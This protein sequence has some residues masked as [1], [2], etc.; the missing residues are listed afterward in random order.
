MD[1]Q[2]NPAGVLD[3][4]HVAHAAQQLAEAKARV[5]EKRKA[6]AVAKK[7]QQ[8]QRARKPAAKNTKRPQVQLT[9]VDFSQVSKGSV[10]KVKAGERTQK[11]TVVEVLKDSARVELENG[12]V[13]NVAADRLFA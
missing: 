9:A 12:L 3:T 10:V 11:A 13:I 7:A 1:L 4:E 2:G 8:K 6:E 5:A